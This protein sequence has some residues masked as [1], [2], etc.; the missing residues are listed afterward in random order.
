MWSFEPAECPC[1]S[2]RAGGS[3][4]RPGETDRERGMVTAEIALGLTALSMV[5]AAG[6]W[7]VSVV[8]DQARCQD[9]ARDVARAIA[10]GESE[11]VARAE[12]RRAA[13]EG[14]RIRIGGSDGWAEVVVSAEATPAWPV[15]AGVGG[16]RVRAEAAVAYEPGELSGPVPDTSELP[17]PVDT[18]ET[19]GPGGGEQHPTD[20]PVGGGGE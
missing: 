12:G 11:R 18:D 13:P 2:R 6:L 16:L 9:A 7:T 8:A 3:T 1:P 4:V 10:R 17:G 15:L 14:A 5:L 20:E 19:P